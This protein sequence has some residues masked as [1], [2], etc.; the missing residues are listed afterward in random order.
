[1]RTRLLL[2]CPGVVLKPLRNAETSRRRFAGF[3]P[4]GPIFYSENRLST[5]SPVEIRWIVWAIRGAT[6]SWRIL[7]QACASAL[8][9]MVL[10]T[11][12]SSRALQIGRAHV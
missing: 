9:G 11:T 8:R 4:Q 12:T 1:M 7:P 3:R 10:V 6:D 2:R 5:E